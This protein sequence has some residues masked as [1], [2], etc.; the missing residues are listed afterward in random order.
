LES[1]SI[2]IILP[3]GSKRGIDYL[4]LNQLKKDILWI[5][6]ENLGQLNAGFAPSGSFN[7][8]YWEYLTIDGDKWFYE[9]DKTFCRTGV[10]VILLCLCVEYNCIA[11]GDQQVFKR[12]ELPTIMDY[13]TYYEVK[14][15]AERRIKEKILMGLNIAISMTPNQLIDTDFEHKDLPQFYENMNEIGDH[16][17]LSY[18]QSKLDAYF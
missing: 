18:Y 2:F 12:E 13:V 9:E 17:M 4:E 14:N 7:S 5:Y 3:N 1:E 8:N 16:F 15:T 11:S 6:D 10:L